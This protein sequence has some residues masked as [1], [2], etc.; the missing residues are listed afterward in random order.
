MTASQQ[1]ARSRD[2]Y[3]TRSPTDL[4]PRPLV[5]SVEVV[6]GIGPRLVFRRA[7]GHSHDEPWQRRAVRAPPVLPDG[8]QVGRLAYYN[9]S[10]T[11]ANSNVLQV[12]AESAARGAHRRVALPRAHAPSAC[13]LR[14]H[15]ATP[16]LDAGAHA[17]HL[18]R[19]SHAE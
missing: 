12:L 10:K 16:W 9:N 13:V 5:R 17:T 6:P 1:G 4:I 18:P 3:S 19:T 8:R 7:P 11:P 2:A 14:S 15:G